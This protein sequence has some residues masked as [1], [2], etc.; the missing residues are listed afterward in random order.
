[1]IVNGYQVARPTLR[2]RIAARLG[3][4]MRYLERPEDREGF[5]SGYALTRCSMHF[6][7]RDRLRI[8]VGGVVVLETAMQTEHDPGRIASRSHVSVVDP[9][10]A[11]LRQ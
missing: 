3:F 5:V 1:M 9:T 10:T 11:A 2:Q 6:D 7:W 8:L 4:R